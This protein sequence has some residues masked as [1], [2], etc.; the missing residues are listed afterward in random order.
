M[1]RPTSSSST[2]AWKEKNVGGTSAPVFRWEPRKSEPEYE[3]EM[4][5]RMMTYLRAPKIRLRNR[6]VH[7]FRRPL[8]RRVDQ[9]R[10]PKTARSFLTVSDNFNAPGAASARTGSRRLTVVDRPHRRHLFRPL[11]RPGSQRCRNEPGIPTN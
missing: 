4:L 1:V 8:L 7:H 11:R 10:S 5:Y 9:A 3:A 6:S 2:A